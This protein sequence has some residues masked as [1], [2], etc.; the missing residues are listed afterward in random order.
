MAAR[1][2]SIPVEIAGA[3]KARQQLRGVHGAVQQLGG[4]EQQQAKTKG[5]LRDATKGA[6]RAQDQYN[7]SAKTAL[8]GILGRLSPEMAGLA[9]IAVDLA[10]GIGGVSTA[11]LGMVGAGAAVAG[12]AAVMEKLAEAARKAKEEFDRLRKARENAIGEART[13]REDVAGKLYEAG[14]P[15]GAEAGRQRVVDL[16][17]QGIPQEAATF[18]AVA[19]QVGG[20]DPAQTRQAI[21]AWL[22]QG[23]QGQF[24][25]DQAANQKLIGELL[26][27]DRGQAEAVL[28]ARIADVGQEARGRAAQFETRSEEQILDIAKDRMVRSGRFTEQEASA[29]LGLATGVHPSRYAPAA[30]PRGGIY[31]GRTYSLANQPE[32]GEEFQRRAMAERLPDSDATLGE[33]VDAIRA[34]AD[35]VRGGGGGGAANVTIN[36]PRTSI[37]VDRAYGGAPGLEDLGLGPDLMPGWSS[38]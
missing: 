35:Y 38:R 36:M 5:R 10:K 26:Q 33:L 32:T 21:G 9:N 34:E 23:K 18:G 14:R 2:I 11:L 20:L 30:G 19:E 8:T 12:I 4:A 25:Q 6:T 16:M 24:T 28:G 7:D 1:K 27:F 13:L 22:A 29:A 37:A 31:A 17:K 3:D 15:G